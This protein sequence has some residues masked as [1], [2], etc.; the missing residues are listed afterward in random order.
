M[1][2]G[3]FYYSYDGDFEIHKLLWSDEIS[4]F[5]NLRLGFVFNTYEESW[6]AGA[7]LYKA[8][9]EECMDTFKYDEFSYYADKEGV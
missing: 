4:D 8:L 3:Q 9:M 2:F 6:R 1:K 5:C 7:L